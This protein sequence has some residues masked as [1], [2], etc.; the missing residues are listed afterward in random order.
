[1]SAEFFGM[2]LEPNG[3]RYQQMN[4][5]SA[6][7]VRNF[8]HLLP[9]RFIYGRIRRR[10]GD[11][12]IKHAAD[13]GCGDGIFLPAL[14]RISSGVVYAVDSDAERLRSVRR[15]K[16]AKVHV[17]KTDA[18]YT[19]IP[20][21]HLDCLVCLET[22]EHVSDPKNVISEMRRILASDG[23]M[24]VSVPVEIGMSVVCKTVMRRL[25]G[26]ACGHDTAYGRRELW[27]AFRGRPDTAYH[28]VHLE[29]KGF[30]YRSI[31]VM[32]RQGGF[33]LTHVWFFPFFLRPLAQ[34]VIV[35]CAIDSKG[36]G[37]LQ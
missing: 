14:S 37:G 12:G 22:L 10:F 21:A 1:M 34:R 3:G 17:C 32:L 11:R 2:P 35:E 26:Y 36:S 7:S 4:Y 28:R 19:G 16:L 9:L 13:V 18:E 27:E 33:K 30:D 8:M 5:F 6:S 24:Y 20:D 15:M 25:L 23:V 29:H 31:M